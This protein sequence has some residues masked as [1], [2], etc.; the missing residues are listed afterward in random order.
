MR[1]LNFHDE[2]KKITELNTVI[3]VENDILN[4]SNKDNFIISYLT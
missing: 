2:N 1:K 4:T 3:L